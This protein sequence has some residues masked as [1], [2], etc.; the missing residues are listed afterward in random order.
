M[1][2]SLSKRVKEEGRLLRLWA[3]PDTP[4]AWKTLL[5][6]GVGL[7]NTDQ[8]TKAAR[9]VR[10]LLASPQKASGKSELLS[11]PRCAFTIIE[12]LV[13]IAVI[14]PSSNSDPAI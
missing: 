11:Q 6:C 4:E 12:L 7:I 8:P 13:V 10:E 9:F 3:T 5:D 14:G 2:R 1:L